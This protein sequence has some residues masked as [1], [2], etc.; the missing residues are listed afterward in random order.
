MKGSA[1]RSPV[2]PG[3][4]RPAEASPGL[5]APGGPP[6]RGPKSGPVLGHLESICPGNGPKIMS[7]KHV[8]KMGLPR[9]HHYPNGITYVFRDFVK[10]PIWDQNPINFPCLAIARQ[11]KIIG[12]WT[13]SETP[14]GGGPQK[15]SYKERAPEAPRGGPPR[16]PRGP[17][18][19]ANSY[20][21]NREIFSDAR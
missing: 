8:P 21:K 9:R 19:G 18:G 6:K 3:G 15:S 16:G 14:P 12:F 1:K 17:R 7:R 2:P 4:S 11:G 10:I 5:G 13:P 20:G